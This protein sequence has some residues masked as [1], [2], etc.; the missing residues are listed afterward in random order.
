MPQFDITSFLPQLIWLGITF[1]VLYLLMWRVALPR[2]TDV[3]ETRSERIA[4]DLDKAAEL[5]AQA[6]SVAAE[7]E[8]ALAEA[9]TRAKATLA[10]VTAAAVAAADAR[11]AEVTERLNKEA[12]AAAQR[13][14]EA[15]SQAM[16]EVRDVAVELAQASVAKLIGREVAADQVAGA[17]DTAMKE[18]S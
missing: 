18:A 16:A 4:S 7:Y 1:V 2:I 11:N 13:I 8:A 14:A 17:V 9:R 6:D 10:E 5:K 12:E 15:K 3:L